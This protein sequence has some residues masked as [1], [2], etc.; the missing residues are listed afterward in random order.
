M[1]QIQCKGY[2][3]LGAPIKKVSPEDQRLCVD[4]GTGH[5]DDHEP[6]MYYCTADSIARTC[7]GPATGPS[8]CE[9]VVRAH[10][11][12]DAMHA[13]CAGG[14]MS[15]CQTCQNCAY[16]LRPP[17]HT[18]NSSV[19]SANCSDSAMR[20]GCGQTARPGGGGSWNSPFYMQWMN[21][22]A[23]LMNGNWYSTQKVSECTGPANTDDCWWRLLSPVAGDAVVNASCANNRIFAA[24]QL[25]HPECWRACGGGSGHASGHGRGSECEVSCVFNTMLGN[26]T[27]GWQAMDTAEIIKPFVHAFDDPAQGGCP[28]VA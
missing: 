5:L 21:K 18:G 8:G 27:L 15:A 12:N 20:R 26:D 16:G 9:A 6:Q 19:I 28:R 2:D 22:F 13:Q 3:Q 17:Q 25:K 14:N 24:L 10:C 1:S 7:S 11:T 4:C 23:C